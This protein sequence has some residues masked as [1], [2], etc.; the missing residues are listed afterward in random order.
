MKSTKHVGR[1][2]V[3]GLILVGGATVPA[4]EGAAATGPTCPG[5]E[6]ESNGLATVFDVTGSG[7]LKVSTKDC[8]I[9]PIEE[10]DRWRATIVKTPTDG[11]QSRVGD[12]SITNFSGEITRQISPLYVYKVIISWDGGLSPGGVHIC[13]ETTGS[14][15]VTPL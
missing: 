4:Q 12:G 2:L 8:C 7:T 6:V 11:A 9:N 1:A 5:T 10:G 14:V 3:L 13:F 15:L